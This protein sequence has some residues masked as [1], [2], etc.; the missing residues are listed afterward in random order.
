MLFRG[1]FDVEIILNCYFVFR[2]FIVN[3]GVLVFLV[4]CV[5]IFV[6]SASFLVV[7][8]CVSP[9]MFLVLAA[10]LLRCSVKRQGSTA[11]LQ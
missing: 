1:L 8:L 11:V 2:L 3:D 7:V 6:Y 4:R 10:L 9:L 5:S